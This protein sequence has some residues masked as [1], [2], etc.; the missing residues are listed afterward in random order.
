VTANADAWDMLVP[1]AGT[2]FHGFYR[3]YP[4]PP[5]TVIAGIKPPLLGDNYVGAGIGIQQGSGNALVIYYGYTDGVWYCRVDTKPN[6][7]GFG[8]RPFSAGAYP[9]DVALFKLED[10]ST[11]IKL[12]VAHDLSGNWQQVYSAGRTAVVA[13]ADRLHFLMQGSSVLA[14]RSRL[15]HW[16]V[17]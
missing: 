8:S 7:S 14:A 11:N 3:A 5:F 16:V 13:A 6:M 15:V 1:A 9:L 10:D 4:T 17:A 2:D 12:S